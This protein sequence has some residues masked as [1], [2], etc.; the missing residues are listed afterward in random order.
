MINLIDRPLIKH[1]IILVPVL[2]LAF[3]L[4]LDEL[5]NWPV[6]WDETFSVWV[7]QMGLSEGTEFTARDV[8]PPLYYWLLYIWVR[9]TGSS[10]FAIRVLS[11]FPSLITILLVYAI[12]RHLSK[13]RLA[14]LLAMLLITASPYHIRWSQDARMY[15]LATMFSSLAIYAYL[16]GNT[17]FIAISG[18][19]A[20][21]SHYF[22]A[23]VVGVIVLYEAV[24]RRQNGRAR[25]HWYTAITVIIAACL[26]WGAY[27]IGLIRRDPSNATF[28]P[29]AAFVLMANVFAVN[30][31]THL[32]TYTMH[33]Q[34][35]T[36]ISFF[37]L[38]L[39]WRDN[40]VTSSFI[41]LGC[42]VPP[43]IIT[44]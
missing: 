29:Q 6:W 10:E 38:L 26:I 36:A 5:G 20:A 44:L 35:I 40:P 12:T 9:V 18:I 30:S 17:R 19:G 34:L 33:V 13:Q 21:L 22:S 27:A 31:T 4:R 41:V 1:T 11:V 28:D 37:G 32:G 2:L 25:R 43:A 23:I 8:H 16:R 24:V 39:S 15:A 14:A 42:L 7:A 3:Y